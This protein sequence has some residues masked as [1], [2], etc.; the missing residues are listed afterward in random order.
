MPLEKQV[1][2]LRNDVQ[3]ECIEVKLIAFPTVCNNAQIKLGFT[4]G[5]EVVVLRKSP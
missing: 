5:L 2:Y 3:M 4:G 1:S